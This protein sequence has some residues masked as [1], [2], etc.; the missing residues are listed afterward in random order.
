[1]FKPLGQDNVMSIL[2][3]HTSAK[4][5]SALAQQ[6]TFH[7]QRTC[8][9]GKELAFVSFTWREQSWTGQFTSFLRCFHR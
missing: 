7:W 2:G 4:V 5:S 1:M 9:A 6:P 3:Q 8:S